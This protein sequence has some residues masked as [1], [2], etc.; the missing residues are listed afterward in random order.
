LGAASVAAGIAMDRILNAYPGLDADKV[1]LAVIY[2][3][4]NPPRGRPRQSA[5]PP[6]NAVVITDRRLSRRRKAE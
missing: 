3:E 6:K 5:E 2:A 4:A 1:E